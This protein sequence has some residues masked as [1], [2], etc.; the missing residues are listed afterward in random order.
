MPNAQPSLPPATPADV[1]GGVDDAPA[2]W[3]LLAAVAASV[4]AAGLAWQV[5]D[6]DAGIPWG[7][8]LLGLAAAMLPLW[9]GRQLWRQSRAAQDQATRLQAQAAQLQTLSRANELLRRAEQ[10]AQLGSFD[11]NPVSGA[12]HWSDEHYRLWGHAPGTLTPDYAAFRARIHPDDVDALE[13]RL[14]HALQTGGI[15]EFTHRLRWP[16]GTEL[17]VLARGDVTRDATGRA[18][19]MLGTVLDITRRRAAEARLQSCT[20][21]C[22]TPS[23]TR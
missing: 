14:Q 13:A 1:A 11:W 16:D 12:L 15:Y 2:P 9:L 5:P 6:T 22:S 10:V 7:T 18:V 23:P 20:S 21:S 3:P 19:R 8:A 17:E 4:A